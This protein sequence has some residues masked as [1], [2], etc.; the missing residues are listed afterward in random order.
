MGCLFGVVYVCMLTMSNALLMSS[1]TVVVRSGDLFWLNPI[2]MVMFILCRVV[3][4][5]AMLCGD[6]WDVVCD[7]WEP[8]LL[9]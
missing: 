2:A 7:V 6:V 8:C 1:A 5:E 4:F 3:A 9:Q